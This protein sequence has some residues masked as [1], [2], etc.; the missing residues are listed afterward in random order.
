MANK[1]RRFSKTRRTSKKTR[2]HGKKTRRHGKKTRRHGKKTRRTGKT[3]RRHG[4]KYRGG[5]SEHEVIFC[6]KYRRTNDESNDNDPTAE[7]LD[8]YLAN[9]ERIPENVN[10]MYDLEL[11]SDVAF[12]GQRKFTFTCKSELSEKEIA[13]LFL[14]QN[15]A[16]GEYGAAP[17]DGSF[18]YPTNDNQNALGLLYFD[19]VIVDGETFIIRVDP[20]DQDN[21]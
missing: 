21:Q 16:D 19:K 9:S 1:T 11:T 15:L 17:G 2:R 13:D 14:E 4:K 6:V 5:E 18:V 12:I 8:D 3:P 7:E 10:Y 20:A